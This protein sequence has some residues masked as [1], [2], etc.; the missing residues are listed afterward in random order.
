MKSICAYIECKKE[1]ERSTHNQK[2]C[3]DDCCRTATNLNIRQKYHENKQRLRGKKR[4]C[5]SRGCNNLLSR[6]NTGRVCQTCE[7][8]NASQVRES[9]LDLVRNVSG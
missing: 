8:S 5:S 2:Y 9:L 6:Y 1:Y 4:V 7:A 3:S